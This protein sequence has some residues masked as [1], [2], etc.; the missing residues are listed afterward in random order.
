[1]NADKDGSLDS[2]PGRRDVACNGT[3]SDPL[4][5][6]G[7]ERTLTRFTSPD[8]KAKTGYY[9]RK[10]DKFSLYS[11]LMN[12]D[13]DRKQVWVTLTYEYIWGRPAGYLDTRAVWLGLG[14]CLKPPVPFTPPKPYPIDSYGRPLSTKPF[15]VNSPLW[16]APYDGQMIEVGGHLHDGGTDIVIYQN[17]KVLCNPVASYGGDS[18]YTEESNG[19]GG[20]SGLQHISRMTGCTMMGSFKKGSKFY[21]TA[22][23][24][25]DMHPG[26]KNNKGKLDE[27]MGIS[28]L[29]ISVPRDAH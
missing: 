15:D 22:R 27:I 2:G 1:L 24:N 10:T 25:F 6:S 12:M 19:G 28:L 26:V 9:I 18:A 29:Y 4:F 14:Q 16:T 20:M 3:G 23:Y 5:A 8:G 7:N 21:L 17:N 13:L 11:E